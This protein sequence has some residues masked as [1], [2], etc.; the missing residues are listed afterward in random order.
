VKAS[1]GLA[2]SWLERRPKSRARICCPIDRSRA[3]MG[4]AIADLE[5]VV[6][7]RGR[8]LCV[9]P[10]AGI[11]LRQDGGSWA[12]FYYSDEFARP[13]RS[14]SW[15]EFKQLAALIGLT[16]SRT[17]EIAPKVLAELRDLWPREPV[18]NRRKR[19]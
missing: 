3:Y 11:L 15:P 4:A 5:H 17:H 16:V 2:E 19:R 1:S 8:P 9:S 6:Q 14:L 10:P 12:R 13:L 18:G 7:R